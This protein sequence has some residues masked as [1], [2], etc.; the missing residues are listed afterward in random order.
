MKVPLRYAKA[1]QAWVEGRVEQTTGV[2]HFVGATMEYERDSKSKGGLHWETPSDAEEFMRLKAASGITWAYIRRPSI[3]LTHY[4]T[5]P[6][7]DDWEIH[8]WNGSS[9]TQNITRCHSLDAA[10]LAAELLVS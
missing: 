7:N 8:V 4:E 5:H 3:A 9:F 2:N 10:M 1:R 6:N